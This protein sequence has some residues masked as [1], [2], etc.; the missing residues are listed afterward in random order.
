MRVQVNQDGLKL[1]GTYQLLV[2][3]DMLNYW[4]E[5][6]IL[7]EKR[8]NLLVANMETGIEVNADK[9]KYIVMYRDQNASRSRNIKIDNISFEMMEE[10]KY[11]GKTLTNQNS[12][13]E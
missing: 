2:Y 1:S 12:I 7:K 9:T 3:A 5:V 8:R 4:E 6:Y 11:L 10:F 13:Q